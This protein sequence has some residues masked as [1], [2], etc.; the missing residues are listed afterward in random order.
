MEGLIRNFE[1]TN[2]ESLLFAQS[3]TSLADVISSNAVDDAALFAAENFKIAQDGVLGTYNSLTS[4]AVDAMVAYDG[5]ASSLSDLNNSMVMSKTA[6]FALAIEIGKLQESLTSMFESSA[7][8]I[9]E[10]L[11]SEADL[12]AARTEERNATLLAIQDMTNPEGI[13]AAAKR[14]NELNDLLF[15]ELSE[16]DKALFGADFAEFADEASVIVKE[17][18]DGTLE[19]VKNS[20][21][22]LITSVGTLLTDTGKINRDAADVLL[23]AATIILDAARTPTVV[24]V[25]V[26]TSGEVTG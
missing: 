1:G 24:A 3:M 11:M 12:T 8:S 2:Q 26:E 5:S 23:N 4:A 14:V 10:Q 21:E 20:Q 13:A 25:N 16:E 19:L 22:E 17:Q 6:A 7:K 9:R 18:L 15:R